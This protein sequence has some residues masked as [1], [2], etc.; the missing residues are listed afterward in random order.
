MSTHIPRCD[1]RAKAMDLRI[2][3]LTQEFEELQQL[4]DRVR[5]AAQAASPSVLLD[6]SQSVQAQA[7][8]V[9]AVPPGV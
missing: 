5:R 1:L 7:P 6:P 4:R 2:R 8:L 9:Q 3:T